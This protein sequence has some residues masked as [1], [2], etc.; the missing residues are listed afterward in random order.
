MSK[1]QKPLEL[2][3]DILRQQHKDKEF[4]SLIVPKLLEGCISWRQQQDAY[5]K[6][7]ETM[8]QEE[9]TDHRDRYIVT[10]KHMK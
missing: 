3:S 6:Q 10:K 7:T 1:K 8:D 4:S 9:L 2:L 5:E